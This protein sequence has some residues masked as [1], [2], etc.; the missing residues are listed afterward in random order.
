MVFFNLTGTGVQ[1]DFTA[2]KKRKKEARQAGLAPAD[3][4]QPGSF[5]GWLF[6]FCRQ[7]LFVI[8][9]FNAYEPAIQSRAAF[10]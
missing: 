3:P 4:L 1:D 8:K 9:T 6:L 5:P 7:L 2:S 10:L